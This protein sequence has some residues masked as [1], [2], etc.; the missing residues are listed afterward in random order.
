MVARGV[1]PASSILGSSYARVYINTHTNLHVRLNKGEAAHGTQVRLTGSNH[2]G[3]KVASMCME[4]HAGSC[5]H[6]SYIIGPGALI[7]ALYILGAHRLRIEMLNNCYVSHPNTTLQSLSLWESLPLNV[8]EGWQP[9][10][11]SLYANAK[12]SSLH[13]FSPL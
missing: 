2:V 12:P 9:Q 3:K 6:T 13:L 4:A 7:P 8:H 11:P 10:G 1:E 5:A